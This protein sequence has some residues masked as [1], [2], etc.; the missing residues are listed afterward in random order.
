[1]KKILVVGSLNMDHI[2]KVGV[3]PKVGETVAGEGLDLIPGGKGAN[4]AVALGKLGALVEMIGIVGR[5]GNGEKLLENLE[6]MNVEAD[7]VMVDED[8]PTGMAFIMINASGDNS[9]VVIPGANSRLL[10]EHVEESW[11]E[12]VEILL[13][14]LET[15]IETVAKVLKTA[16][17]RG[18][19][20]VLNPAPACKLPEDCL[21]NTDL[22]IPNETEFEIL[23]GIRIAKEQDF[24]DGFRILNKQGISEMIVT[25]G[26][27]GSWYFNGNDFYDVK[28]LK[29][30]PV[31]TTAAGDSFIGGLTYKLS[32]GAGIKEAMEFGTRVA[33]IAITRIGA[34]SSLPYI[35]ELTETGGE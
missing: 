16:R 9:I 34:Q 3:T 23:T 11:F 12:G 5:D 32:I 21:A 22:L 29:V 2:T 25:L 35:E 19:K 6:K 15:P 18:I 17:R 4:Q 13:C 31:D 10:P 8:N 7:R 1:M 26:E 28:S 24:R 14:Q 27:R 30:K 20:T 33:A